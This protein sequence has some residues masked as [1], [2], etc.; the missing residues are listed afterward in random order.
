VKNTR[1]GFGRERRLRIVFA[2]RP[3]PRWLRREIARDQDAALIDAAAL[4]GD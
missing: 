3:A 1:Y 4:V 2:G